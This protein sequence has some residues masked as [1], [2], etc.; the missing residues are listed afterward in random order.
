MTQGYSLEWFLIRGG[1]RWERSDRCGFNV[2]FGTV[3]GRKV[4]SVSMV[5]VSERK[6]GKKKV[7]MAAQ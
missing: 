5:L 7:P 6:K 4:E 1:G 2:T 3:G